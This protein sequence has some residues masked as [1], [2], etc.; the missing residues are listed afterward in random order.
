MIRELAENPNVYQPLGPGRS[1]HRDPAGR[2]AIYLGDGAS[3]RSA[4]VQ[5]V[6]LARTDVNAAVEEIRS[7]LRSLGRDGTEWELGES[8]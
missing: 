7:F 5:R 6:R 2:F 1:L 3:P 4:T 8:C